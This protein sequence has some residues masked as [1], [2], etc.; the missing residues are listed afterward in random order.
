MSDCEGWRMRASR[1]PPT[2]AAKT[3][4][5]PY[6]MSFLTKSFKLGYGTAKRL[7]TLA[8]VS[9]IGW[10]AYTAVRNR[11]V[12]PLSEPFPSRLELIEGADGAMIATHISDLGA[13]PVATPVLLIHG[14]NAAASSAEMR[15]LFERL[16]IDRPTTAMDLP[17][18]GHSD[19]SA[20]PYTPELMAE[21]VTQVLE[22]L[23][24]PAHVVALSLTSE[25]VARA[26]AHHPEMVRSITMISPTG[27]GRRSRK[28]ELGSSSWESLLKIPLVGQALYDLLV[29]KQS[30]D[31]F[32]A[33][34]FAGPVDSELG[35][36]AIETGRQPD[37]R[38]APIAFLSGRLFTPE[39]LGRLY[40][41]L[42]VPTLVI[43]DDDAYTDFADLPAFVAA[44]NGTRTVARIPGTKGLPHFDEPGLTIEALNYF[45]KEIESR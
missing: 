18:F 43:Y 28:E 3:G 37:A 5:V 8:T 7:P 41:P 33:K 1:S 35:K 9:T 27:M 11:D 31:Y 2:F 19:R 44:G 21:A 34:S 16:S 13:V 39:A 24:Q 12:L 38:H 26:A 25:F 20:R 22:S 15:P 45:W 36:A 4:R 17:G 30:I 6:S 40:Q 10:L 14:V 29:T 23:T 32:L 42:T